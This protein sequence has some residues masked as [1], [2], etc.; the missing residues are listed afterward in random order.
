MT[1]K[2]PPPTRLIARSSTP[3][4]SDD[5]PITARPSM[6]N[7]PIRGLIDPQTANVAS[8]YLLTL[9]KLMVRPSI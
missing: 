2:T 3:F 9:R 1:W 5:Y 8:E 4:R 7:D 6:S